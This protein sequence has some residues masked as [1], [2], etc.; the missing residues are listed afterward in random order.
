M[1]ATAAEITEAIRLLERDVPKPET[2][3]SRYKFKPLNELTPGSL[4]D[5]L[6]LLGNRC[7]CRCGS[8]LMIGRTGIGK[9]SFAMQCAL[10][11]GAGK[12]AFG[13][14]PA[15]VLKSVFV[16]AENDEGDLCEMREGVLMGCGFSPAESDLAQS[17]IIIDKVDDRAGDNLFPLLDELLTEH[18]PDL[19]W[20][21]PLLSFA[22]CNLSAQAEITPFLRNQLQP[23]VN[24]HNCAVIV[25]HHE[26]KPPKEDNGNTWATSDYAYAG[27]GSAD[28]ANW[29][30]AVLVVR[31]TQSTGL[32]EL[33]AAKRGKR[34]EWVDDQGQPTTTPPHRPR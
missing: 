13:I 28:L 18:E 4:Y 15:G 25:L 27:A 32:F 6:T 19:L 9:S 12:E 29:A 1:N 33:I 30:R 11:W 34:L 17:N 8:L 22:G 5:G 2:I 24:K 10:C 26:V 31:S 7:L 16:Q 14:K 23:L 3:L 21:D 20:L